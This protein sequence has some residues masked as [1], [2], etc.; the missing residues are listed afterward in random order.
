VNSITINPDKHRFELE[1]EGQVAFTVFKRSEGSIE[2]LHTMVPP[3]LEGKGIG[4]ALAK[5]A[6]AYAKENGLE[7]IVTCPFIQ[8][9]LKKHPE[10]A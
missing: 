4:S 9:W 5:H 8:A 7:A 1:T 10:A 6:M 3:Q 2:Y